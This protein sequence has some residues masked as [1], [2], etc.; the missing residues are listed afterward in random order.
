MRIPRNLP[1]FVMPSDFL[2]P[3]YDNI[4]AVATMD[5]DGPVANKLKTLRTHQ[6]AMTVAQ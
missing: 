4:S 2:S 5:I 1:P 3:S 6:L